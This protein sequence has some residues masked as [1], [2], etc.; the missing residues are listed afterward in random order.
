M[1]N[2]EI[3]K[4]APKVSRLPLPVTDSPLVI[5]LP[6]GQKIVVGKMTEGS[7]IEV[8]TWRGVGRPDSRTSRLMLGVGNGDVNDDSDDEDEEGNKKPSR[9][10][11]KGFAGIVFT[12]QNFFINFSRINWAATFKGIFVSLASIKFRMPRTPKLNSR[13]KSAMVG[14]A[15]ELAIGSEIIERTA[16]EEAEFDA[17]V[18]QISERAARSAAKKSPAK[19]RAV[20][21]TATKKAPAK[22]APA[23]KSG[24]TK[25]SAASS[26]KRR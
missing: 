25:K 18:N 26:A 19:K 20:K 11:P 21:K 3:E 12:I 13:R 22:K 16:E 6:D 8:A 1:A 17:W 24:T 15:G 5:D 23:K 9:P 14:D 7:V 4:S 10:K 2:Q